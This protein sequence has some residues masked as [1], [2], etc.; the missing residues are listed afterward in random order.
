M[1]NID[2]E[3]RGYVRQKIEYG[4]NDFADCKIALSSG[5]SRDFWIA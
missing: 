4:L 5:I 3:Y 2:D 1:S